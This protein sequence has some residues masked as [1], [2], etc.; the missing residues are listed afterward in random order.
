MSR[1]NVLERVI[2][3]RKAVRAE[4]ALH[5]RARVRA[6]DWYSRETKRPS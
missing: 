3:R 2:M 6:Q 4:G 1:S 5:T